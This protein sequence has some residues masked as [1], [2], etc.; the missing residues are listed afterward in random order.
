MHLLY[1]RVLP[2]AI[3]II[4]ILNEPILL[5]CIIQKNSLPR[6]I[7]SVHPPVSYT[8]HLYDS[9][10][11]PYHILKKKIS[12][13]LLRLIL[14]LQTLFFHQSPADY[15]LPKPIIKIKRMAKAPSFPCFAIFYSL[16]RPYLWYGSPA[17][18]RY[19]RYTCSSSITLISWCGNVIGEKLSL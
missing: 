12:T 16:L 4:T 15:R 13:V 3:T 14:I 2:F 1:L 18:I 8:E 6:V 10:E 17:I 5:F 11:N 7:S 19:D 9:V